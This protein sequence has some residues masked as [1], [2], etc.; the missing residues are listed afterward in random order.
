MKGL[1][2][3]GLP[4][5]RGLLDL[6]ALQLTLRNHFLHEH[7]A[8]LAVSAE[9]K[10]TLRSALGTI[11][12][13]ESRCLAEGG[14]AWIGVLEVAAQRFQ[15]LVQAVCFSNVHDPLLRRALKA[16]M[17]IGELLAEPAI[18]EQLQAVTEAAT[19]AAAPAAPSATDASTAH[20]PKEET[21]NR[22]LGEVGAAHPIA[23]QVNLGSNEE[24]KT[25]PHNSNPSKRTPSRGWQTWRRRRF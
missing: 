7:L 23:L 9:S 14:V 10:A 21:D 3:R 13:F 18:A 8:P 11:P 20:D 17:S 16:Q 2:G 4:G 25:S 6:V 15:R 22:S 19:A 1:S 24:P 5:N 12:D